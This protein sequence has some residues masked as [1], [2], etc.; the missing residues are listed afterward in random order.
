MDNLREQVMINQFVMAAGCAREQARQLLQS[1][2]WH[3]ERALTMFFQ[4]ASLPGHH[5]HHQL[6]TPA[7]TPV[8]P[9]NFPDAL[10]ALSKLS[11]TERA[12]PTC[13]PNAGMTS[14]T[15][16]CASPVSPPSYNLNQQSFQQQQ[17]SFGMPPNNTCGNLNNF[18]NNFT[19]SSFSSPP[20]VSSPTHQ[21]S[22][23]RVI[24]QR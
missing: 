22:A 2:Q 10:L 11:T 24:A 17:Q 4:E 12:S 19:S 20:L 5:H 1:S 6:K 9:P 13:S 16:M 14:P 15:H 7:N 23:P 3:F 8:T 21:Q 18:S